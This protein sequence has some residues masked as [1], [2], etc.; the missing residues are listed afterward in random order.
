[1]I[2]TKEDYDEMIDDDPFP[3]YKHSRMPE[4]EKTLSYLTI[5][6]SEH[7]NLTSAIAKFGPQPFRGTYGTNFQPPGFE[8][9]FQ[10]YDDHANWFSL[11]P[12]RPPG[13]LPPGLNPFISLPPISRGSSNPRYL[14]LDRS[15][16]PLPGLLPPGLWRPVQ[17]RSDFPSTESSVSGPSR[18]EGHYSRNPPQLFDN[19]SES[20]QLD[21]CNQRTVV[22]PRYRETA[23]VQWR[24]PETPAHCLLVVG[25][26]SS[27]EDDV[28]DEDD[29]GENRYAG[30]SGFSSARS[31][32]SARSNE[33][34]EMIS[35]RASLTSS[36][37][38]PPKA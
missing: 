2:P 12:S 17:L 9:P 16:P 6:G 30:P 11:G 25:Y 23:P 22:A 19:S 27:D 13:L 35:E 10:Q 15:D 4:E 31:T 28:E 3:W 29:E 7:A 5:N 1:M 14:A 8:R 32:S 34:T 37:T 26:E 38:T 36:W 21:P 18:P 33:T 20:S 24:S